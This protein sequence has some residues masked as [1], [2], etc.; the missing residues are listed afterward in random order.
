MKCVFIGGPRDGEINEF[1]EL[2]EIR[3]MRPPDIEP[4]L[5]P[6]EYVPSFREMKTYTYVQTSRGIYHYK[7]H[8]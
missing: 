4:M 6:S 7:G 8:N 1:P 2:P 5:D 3:F